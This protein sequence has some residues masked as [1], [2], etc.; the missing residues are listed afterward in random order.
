VI[1]KDHFSLMMGAGVAL[2]AIG[3][4][5]IEFGGAH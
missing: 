2:I 4:G 3:V 5:L 1:F